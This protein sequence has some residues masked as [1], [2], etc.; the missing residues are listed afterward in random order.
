MGEQEIRCTLPQ[1][2]PWMCAKECVADGASMT[3]FP[4]LY[5]PLHRSLTS[6]P[7]CRCRA[8]AHVWSCELFTKRADGDPVRF[9]RAVPRGDTVYL[10]VPTLVDHTQ[11]HARRTRIRTPAYLESYILSPSTAARAL[12]TPRLSYCSRRWLDSGV[13]ISQGD[14]AWYNEMASTGVDHGRNR[15]ERAI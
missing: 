6:H 7:S 14:L 5:L 10:Q 11:Q 8:A 9:T 15:A 3:V 2:V 12:T 13:R 1:T 4:P